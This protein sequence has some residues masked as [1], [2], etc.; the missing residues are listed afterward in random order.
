MRKSLE[1]LVGIALLLAPSS[2]GAQQWIFDAANWGQPPPTQ[3]SY[4][5]FT[6]LNG[7]IFAGGQTERGSGNPTARVLCSTDD[8]L[9]WQ[10][11]MV[12][13]AKNDSEARRIYA[14]SG[15]SVLAVTRSQTP[16][17]YR[18]IDGGANW[19]LAQELNSDQS[20]GR[21][22]VEFNGAIYL[23]MVAL[24]GGPRVYRST[25][26]GASWTSVAQFSSKL[27]HISSLL[28]A[29]GK[30]YA[31]TDQAGPG[32]IGWVFESADGI[33]WSKKNATQMSG[34]KFS[35]AH[36][37][38]FF[39]GAY[40]AG[41]QDVINGGKIWQSPD[42]VTWSLVW[43]SEGRVE[44]EVYRLYVTGS[45]MWAGTRTLKG[46]GGRVYYTD[47]GATFT[48]D[49]ADGFGDVNLHGPFDFIWQDGFLITSQRP[50]TVTSD[51]ATTA[52]RR[53]FTDSVVPGG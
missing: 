45:R 39:N 46:T 24:Q 32:G 10:P 43:Q 9:T 15:G 1:L 11:V 34:Q 50:L 12:P 7:E 51:T 5:S 21:W 29:N 26:D 17:V 47:D 18:S 20:Y 6:S 3:N 48:Q 27:T 42:L 40:Y 16:K 30:L 37:L 2:V 14:T 38:T 35:L 28:V 36:S 23:A 49:G 31:S 41:E 8:G 25:D 13:F 53:V 19:L 22:F 4:Y 52:Q 33:Q 44:P